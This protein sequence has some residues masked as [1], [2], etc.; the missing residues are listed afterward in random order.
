MHTP[1]DKANG[2][3]DLLHKGLHLHAERTTALALGDRSKYV[4]LSDIG[5]ALECPRAA[6][7]NKISPRPQVSLQKLLTLQRGHWF[8]YGIGQAFAVHNLHI[9]P[10]L[11]LAFIHNGVP[12]KAHLDFTLVWDKPHPAV[13]ILELKSTEHLPETL[14]TLYETQLYGQ[15]SFLAEFWN[16][17]VF[18]LKDGNGRI[19]HRN[20]TMP[21]LCK[22]HFGLVLPAEPTAVDMEAWVLCIS[23]SDAKAFGPYLRNAA[24]RDLCLNTAETLWQHKQAVENGQIDINAVPHATGFH[25]LCASCDWNADCPKFHDG[26]YQPEWQPELDRLARLK[27]SR[28][29]LD[30]E[31]ETLEIG[32]KD[33]YTLATMQ[34]SWISTGSYRFRVTSSNGRRTLDREALRS[35]LTE[36]F[37]FEKLDEI[38]VN[39]LLKRCEQESRAFSRLVI[40]EIN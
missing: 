38:D 14:Y 2:L 28:S 23:M 20:Q 12:I 19:L 13:R 7:L 3:L 22:A 40:N 26:E 32:L 9:L 37:H 15:A 6:L 5:R 39:A 18:S 17:P 31:I 25:A 10:Q 24:M 16:M 34:G 1:S 8:E 35:E 11:E 29:A 27:N 21:Q 36:I 4:G 30:A 33:A